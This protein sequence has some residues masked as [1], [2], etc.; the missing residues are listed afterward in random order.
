MLT[1]FNIKN[2]RCFKDFSLS[3]LERINLITGMNNVGK[4]ALL[5]GM[6]LFAGATNPNLAMIIN[7]FR[8]I[9]TIE[10]KPDLQSETPWNSL[11]YNL[12]EDAE[13]VMT[14][15]LGQLKQRKLIIKVAR[16]ESELV[17]KPQKEGFVL[18][19]ATGKI[20]EFEYISET[21][22]TIKSKMIIGSQGVKVELPPVP[23]PFSAIFLASRSRINP[24]EDTERFS[25]IEISSQQD[26]LLKILNIIEPRLKRLTVAVTAGVPMIY[27]DI[28]L[29]RLLPL[30]LMGEGLVRVCSI[31]LAIANLP[32]GIVFIDEIENGVHYSIMDKIWLGIAEAARQFNTQIF[33]TTH[34][35]ECITAAHYVFSQSLIYDFL[36]HRLDKINGNIAAKTYDREAL[37]AAI[38]TE[39]EVR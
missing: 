23:I 37:S 6:F 26:V 1:S 20:L 39:L 5:E 8:G 9:E 13:I 21:G 34:S 29:N 10:V 7:A 24:A 28:G 33:A 15:E 35:R 30:S 3:P 11:F 25:K 4:T 38:N 2:F 22:K 27:G 18:S 31:V 14:G 16:K 19:E 32:N 17:M 12:N 36:L